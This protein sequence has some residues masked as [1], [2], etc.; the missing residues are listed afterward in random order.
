[1]EN[2]PQIGELN[3]RQKIN[4]SVQIGQTQI[5]VDNSECNPSDFTVQKCF[6]QR[7][8]GRDRYCVYI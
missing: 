8:T 6:D 2:I 3:E 7:I 1:M 5:S 4:G